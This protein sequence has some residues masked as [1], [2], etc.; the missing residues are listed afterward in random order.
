[1]T[2]S[3]IRLASNVLVIDKKCAVVGIRAFGE[4][5]GRM[6]L[7]F[8]VAAKTLG[9][10]CH[11]LGGQRVQPPAQFLDYLEDWLLRDDH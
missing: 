3:D 2:A 9:A 11:K 10:A 6:P 8:S 1:M 4:R 7:F 5:A